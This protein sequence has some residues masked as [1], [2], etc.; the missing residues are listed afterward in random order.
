M[1]IKSFQFRDLRAKAATDTTEAT[2]DIRQAQRQLG[3]AALSM[4]EHYT[5][6]RRG[7]AVK[8]GL[9]HT[10]AELNQR[11]AKHNRTL[12]EADFDEF[13]KQPGFTKPSLGMSM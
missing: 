13:L 8:R 11:I 3:H 4:T 2:G 1:D 9:P 12:T 10:T 5:R 7:D 6:Q